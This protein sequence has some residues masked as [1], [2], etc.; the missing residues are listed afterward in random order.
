MNEN[1]ST[2]LRQY[3]INLLFAYIQYNLLHSLKILHIRVYIYI[4][5]RSIQRSVSRELIGSLFNLPDFKSKCEIDDTCSLYKIKLTFNSIY[6]TS[7][8]VR[9]LKI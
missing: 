7:Q 6:A 8:N 5:R 2:F 9:K 4:R 3:R 1:C